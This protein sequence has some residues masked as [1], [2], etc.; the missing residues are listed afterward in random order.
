MNK[1]AS[2]STIRRSGAG[3]IMHGPSIAHG[4]LSPQRMMRGAE[5]DP[6]RGFIIWDTQPT[7]N[8][9]LVS[10]VD[11]AWQ[12]LEQIRLERRERFPERTNLGRCLGKEPSR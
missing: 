5:D 12:V 11:M 10:K 1:F 2:R 4:I 6:S 9:L 3:K 7:R 8:N